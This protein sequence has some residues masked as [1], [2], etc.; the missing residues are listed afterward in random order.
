[1]PPKSSS[2]ADTRF[3]ATCRKTNYLADLSFSECGQ[4]G[5]EHAFLVKIMSSC[6][7]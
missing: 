7:H 2:V 1:M 6:K 4:T 5:E 3:G